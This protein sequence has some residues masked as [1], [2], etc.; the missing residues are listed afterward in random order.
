MSLTTTFAALADPT[1]RGLLARLRTGELTVG[2]LAA[3]YAMSM[4][5][6]TKHLRVLEAAGL[7]RRRKQGRQVLCA[8][9]RP[10]QDPLEEAAAW[11][12]D[13]QAYWEGALDRL[14]A[15][16]STPTPVPEESP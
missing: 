6:V 11:I 7:I 13:Q 16:V 12:R 3:P 14:D 1:R 4:P 8:L 9:A 10:E 2:A 15:L 5:A